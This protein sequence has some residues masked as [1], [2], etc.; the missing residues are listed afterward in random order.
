MLL[1]VSGILKTSWFSKQ[2]I[3]TDLLTNQ[4]MMQYAQHLSSQYNNT[5]FCVSS[6]LEPQ[7]ELFEL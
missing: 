7:E 6:R 5:N 1:N 4:Q 3:M 2:V